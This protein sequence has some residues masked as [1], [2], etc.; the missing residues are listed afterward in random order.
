[1]QLSI[2]A[3]F[4]RQTLTQTSRPSTPPLRLS[5]ELGRGP[6]KRLI[7]ASN[8]GEYGDPNVGIKIEDVSLWPEMRSQGEIFLVLERLVGGAGRGS[9]SGNKQYQVEMWLEGV[10]EAEK[11]MQ[12]SSWVEWD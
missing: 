12:V 3:R 10:V 1:M 6:E 7:I 2:S 11:A 5:L 8:G 9:E 4:S